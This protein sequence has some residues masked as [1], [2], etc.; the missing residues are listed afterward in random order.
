MKNTTE[1]EISVYLKQ[2]KGQGGGEARPLV[3]SVCNG[4]YGR[5][6]SAIVEVQGSPTKGMAI[7]R[8]GSGSLDDER[9]IESGGYTV[10]ILECGSKMRRLPDRGETSKKIVRYVQGIYLANDTRELPEREQP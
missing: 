9:L 5:P 3:V 6:S 7:V 10:W 8:I 4:N 1:E 2:K